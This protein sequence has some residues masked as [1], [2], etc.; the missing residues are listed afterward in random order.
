MLAEIG[1]G[2]FALAAKA[3]QMRKDLGGEP[4]QL[5][6]LA[7]L[8][9]E[10]KREDYAAILAA[11]EAGRDVGDL[12]NALVLAWAKVGEGKMSEAIEAFDAVTQNKGL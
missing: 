11:A 6:E 5:A 4:S 12:A 7:L 3:A 9:D 10:A 2:D 8:A 1:I